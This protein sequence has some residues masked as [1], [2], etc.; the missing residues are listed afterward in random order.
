MV[1][2]EE[3]LKKQQ[4]LGAHVQGVVKAIANV[5]KVVKKACGILAFISWHKI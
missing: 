5:D 3:V 2:F 4:D 1:G